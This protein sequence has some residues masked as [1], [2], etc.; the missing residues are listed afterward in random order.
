MNIV[1]TG[2]GT[3]GHLYPALNIARE[4]EKNFDNVNIIYIGAP[5]SIEEEVVTKTTTYKFYSID[6]EGLKGLKKLH[7]NFKVLKK[8]VV[9]SKIC[10]K[11]LLDNKIDFAIGTGGYVCAPVFQSARKLNIPYYIHE[12]NSVFGKVVKFYLK[13]SAATFTSFDNMLNFKPARYSNV[14]FAGNPQSYVANKI[15]TKNI[16]QQVIIYSGSMGGYYFN[17]NIQKLYNELGKMNLHFIHI[18]GKNQD[19]V[20]SGQKNIEVIQ[21]STKL[22]SLISE[23]KFVI[24]RAGASTISELIGLKKPAILVPSPYV[25]HKHQH[26]NASYL[27]NKNCALQCEENQMTLNL[28]SQ[29]K[30]LDANTEIFVNNYDKIEIKKS[31]DIIVAKIKGDFNEKFNKPI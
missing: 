3:G 24:C 29:I 2:G 1:I 12:Q 23:S 7:K 17:Q 21:Y 14:I 28:I 16:K 15:Q 4:L 9:A 26:V 31:L 22:L 10:Q 13:K 6:I 27:T 11:I 19:L 25:A 5:N 30:K 8:F 20:E 18:I